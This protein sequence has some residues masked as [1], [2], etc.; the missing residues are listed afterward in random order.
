MGAGHIAARVL[1]MRSA[2]HSDSNTTAALLDLQERVAALEA[3]RK[4]IRFKTRA[5]ATVIFLGRDTTQTDAERAEVAVLA[6]LAKCGESAAAVLVLPDWLV[7][8]AVRAALFL[9]AIEGNPKG[10]AEAVEVVAAWADI[11]WTRRLGAMRQMGNDL[12]AIT[13]NVGRGRK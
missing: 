3:D 4:P 10:M 6:E 5:E 8:R 13:W 2:L 9:R 12:P 7:W 1:E 11:G